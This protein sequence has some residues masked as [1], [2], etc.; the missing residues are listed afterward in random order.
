MRDYILS[1]GIF[2][3]LILLLSMLVC[4]VFKVERIKNRISSFISDREGIS[5][6]LVSA[7]L[8]LLLY[9]RYIFGDSVYIY[10]DLGS[11][12]DTQY[13]PFYVDLVNS[14]SS[15]SI[16]LWNFNYGLGVS[17]MMTP[18]WLLDIFNLVLIPTALVFGTS[19]IPLA[20]AVIQVMKIILSAFFFDMFL[21][22]YCKNPYARIIGSLLYAFSGF[23]MLWG[24]H[25][26]FSTAV[27]WLSLLLFLL[28]RAIQL[29]SPKRLLILAISF[30]FLFLWG[31]YVPF[32]ITVFLFF[33][34]IFRL[35]YLCSPFK[36]KDYFRKM[37]LLVVSV[38]VGIL[39]ASVVVFPVV[40]SLIF[41]STRVF[42]GEG[43]SK[44]SAVLTSFTHG[45][46]LKFLGIELTRF[47]GNSLIGDAT[48]DYP[49]LNYYEVIQIGA[50]VGFYVFLAFYLY[51]IVKSARSK[52]NKILLLM[53]VL[54]V[55]FYIS[56]GFLPESFS[57]FSA[58][59]F[60]SSFVIVSLTSLMVAFVIENVVIQRKMPKSPLMIATV[61][62]LSLLVVCFIKGTGIAK[63]DVAGFVLLL[64]VFSVC[65]FVYQNRDNLYPLCLALCIVISS[66]M[67]D[68]YITVN[69]RNV[70]TYDDAPIAET[71]IYDN[72]TEAALEYIRSSSDRLFRVEKTYSETTTFLDGFSQNYNGVSSYDSTLA[73]GIQEFYKN[74]W[75]EAVYTQPLVT[76][77]FQLDFNNYSVN[78]FLGI[79]YILSHEKLDIAN[80]EIVETFGS[81][82]LY[83][84]RE[85]ASIGHLYNRTVLESDFN[86]FSDQDKESI[87]ASS[88]VT[89]QTIFNGNSIQESPKPID[90]YIE[91][92]GF[93]KGAYTC[94]EDRI[95]GIS[96]P[97]N[98]GWTVLIDG[99]PVDT[100]VVNYGFIGFEAPSGAH[101]VELKYEPYGMKEGLCVTAASLVLLVALYM[102]YR[103]KSVYI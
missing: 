30:G 3:C 70:R 84:N 31:I 65:L 66:V 50:S 86:Q 87:L 48:N 78:S 23:M 25:Y 42:S 99:N 83:Q 52:K 18:T 17:S 93:I 98:K 102:V 61:F 94:N 56:N 75:P 103:R 4:A 71:N 47:L 14:I 90:L 73:E 72:D 51:W 82:Y 53:P 63:I 7:F 89:E 101:N 74:I 9:S 97:A 16:S 43:S 38:V 41:S 1:N 24:A 96:I 85:E 67:F 39:I 36:A 12:T 77:L 20:L 58:Y 45:S 54:L 62:T 5:V 81:V 28:E 69:D 44:L 11:D 19:V 33:F 64:L 68:G 46:S 95:A 15:G 79:E 76:Q 55:V 32:M 26:W 10:C 34:G 21:R 60:R 59:S 22:Y 88:L 13:I 80:Y 6:C 37:L 27:V 40:D 29:Q 2:L 100:F 49:V 35:A 91:N 57:F 8:A 92:E